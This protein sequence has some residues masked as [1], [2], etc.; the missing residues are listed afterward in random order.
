M[1]T[2]EKQKS[3]LLEKADTRKQKELVKICQQWNKSEITGDDAMHQIWKLFR[4][5]NLKEWNKKC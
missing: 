5:E 3:Q 2:Q 1:N 4:K